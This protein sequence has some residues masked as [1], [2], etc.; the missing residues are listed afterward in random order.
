E[1]VINGGMGG[2]GGMAVMGHACESRIPTFARLNRSPSFG[3][4]ADLCWKVVHRSA[5]RGGGPNGPNPEYREGC[6][7]GRHRCAA[8]SDGGA[9]RSRPHGHAVRRSARGAYRCPALRAC[10]MA[11]SRGASELGD[12]DLTGR[13]HARPGK[14]RNDADGWK[15]RSG[16][17]AA[18]GAKTS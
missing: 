16:G 17:D 13:R 7:E 8:R 3:W 15:T 12:D 18:R 2:D 10:E 11:P 9:R 1:R 14:Y 6:T 5:K 4:Q